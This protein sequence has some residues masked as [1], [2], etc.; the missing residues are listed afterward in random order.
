MASKEIS[1]SQSYTCPCNC[2]W[3]YLAGSC[4]PLLFENTVDIP[5]LVYINRL[6]KMACMQ[7]A[8][9]QQQVKAGVAMRPVRGLAPLVRCSAV[10]EQKQESLVQKL[11]MPVTAAVTAAA[12]LSCVQLAAP[13]EALAARSGGRA[14]ASSFA[15][16]R[17]A[18]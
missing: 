9:L 3:R 6:L 17:A 13:G 16:R 7:R 5:L 18:P 12:V 4:D 2:P 15:A 14:G 11:A 10:P 8:G 1:L